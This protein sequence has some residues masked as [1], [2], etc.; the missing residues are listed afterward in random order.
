[1]CTRGPAQCTM[2]PASPTWL[3]APSVALRMLSLAILAFPYRAFPLPRSISALWASFT[4]HA[5]RA[6][7]ERGRHLVLDRQAMAF[8]LHAWTRSTCTKLLC[9]DGYTKQTVLV[10]MQVS[11][12]LCS[13]TLLGDRCRGAR[14]PALHS[15]RNILLLPG[16]YPLSRLTGDRC[17]AQERECLTRRSL[18]MMLIP[19]TTSQIHDTCTPDADEYVQ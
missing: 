8:I 5:S 4:S 14:L 2:E 11:A 1:M 12:K 3:T 6:L 15:H 10:I 17:T 9:Y 16:I 19:P 18:P 7:Q 13:A